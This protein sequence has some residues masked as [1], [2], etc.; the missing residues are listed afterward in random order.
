MMSMRRFSYKPYVLLLI[1][2]FSVFNLPQMAAERL[3]SFAV[4]ALSP[5]WL[6]LS[7]SKSSQEKK[8]IEVSP[9]VK[10]W[11]LCEERL[12]EEWQRFEK[13]LR[14][15]QSEGP[16]K[17]FFAR[18]AKELASRLELQAQAL[19]AKVIFREPAAW[20]S[21]VWIDVGEEQNR[22]LKQ[23]VISKNSPVLS[24][25]SLIGV[26]EYVEEHRSRVRLITDARLNLAVRVVRG[27]EQNRQMLEQLETLLFALN[28]RDDLFTSEE[29]RS[30]FLNSLSALSQ[31]LDVGT[32]DRYLAKGEIFGCNAPLWR[33]RGQL[34]KGVGFNYDFADVEGPARDLRTGEPYD[35]AW[36][37]EPLA[38]IKAGDMLVTSGLD[39]ICPAGLRVALV[40]KVQPLKEGASSY[41]IQAS[42]TAGDLDNLSHVT[43][44]PALKN[45]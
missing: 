37:K 28:R 17:E 15:G 34:L 25:A 36:K 23:S 7:S 20:S 26:V 21:A 29:E 22:R 30:T 41:E 1:F 3:R 19:P 43:I 6:A 27:R 5:A 39:G 13:L 31:K 8:E 24:G 2:Y 32:E 38:L 40:S 14:A 44:L 12:Q 4:A 42:A 16:W 11:L 18:R 10:E 35:S 45:G 9:Q 33:S